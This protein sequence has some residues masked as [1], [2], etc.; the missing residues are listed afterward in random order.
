MDVYQIKNRRL[1]KA[2]SLRYPIIVTLADMVETCFGVNS[3]PAGK[4]VKQTH[5]FLAFVCSSSSV[6]GI[7]C[8]EVII[9][10]DVAIL[11]TAE[12]GKVRPPPCYPLRNGPRSE[13]RRTRDDSGQ[14]EEA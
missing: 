1:A 10:E 8:L 2:T 3:K 5:A 11:R 7:S 12:E 6:H 4:R 14:K 13:S 9:L